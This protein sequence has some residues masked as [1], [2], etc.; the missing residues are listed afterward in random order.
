M[1]KDNVLPIAKNLPHMEEIMS[2]RSN[3]NTKHV[4]KNE[5]AVPVI[6]NTIY[7]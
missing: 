3:Y 4:Q 6:V 7:F 1:G 5:T 2:T